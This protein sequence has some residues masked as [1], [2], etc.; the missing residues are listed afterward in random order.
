MSES[1]E[2]EGM[3]GT[4]TL[5]VHSFRIEAGAQSTYT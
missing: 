3:Q 2:T 1:E 5:I 4:L